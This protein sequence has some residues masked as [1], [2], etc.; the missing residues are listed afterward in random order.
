[1]SR[2]AKERLHDLLA[3]E[4]A[5]RIV[6]GEVGEGASLPSEQL[7]VDEYQ[8]SRPV[9]RAAIQQLELAGLVQIRH[10]KRTVALPKYDW[11]VMDELVQTAFLQDGRT[12]ELV[13][14]F[15]SVRLVL[16]P[17]VAAWASQRATAA[18]R[19][20]LQRVCRYMDELS[21]SG[22]LASFLLAGR[23]FHSIIARS[24]GNVVLASLMRALH[25]V[26][27]SS[28]GVAVFSIDDL[29]VMAGQHWE[30]AAAIFERNSLSAEDSMRGHLEW[31]RERVISALKTA[32]DGHVA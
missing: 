4:L 25:K 13:S 22:N 2:L 11:D 12:L 8:V 15:Y 9:V 32:G 30:I 14:D 21:H 10:G 6:S 16:E 5:Q 3:R 28:W 19:E 17:H 20:E 31:S 1:M 7:L 29:S 18:Y 23:D 27:T 26:D 24:A